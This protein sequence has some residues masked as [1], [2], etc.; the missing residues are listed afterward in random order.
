MSYG[1]ALEQVLSVDRQ[2]IFICSFNGFW[3]QAYLPPA[4]KAT[5]QANPGIAKRVNRGVLSDGVGLL[6]RCTIRPKEERH[7]DLRAPPS[8]SE[9]AESALCC[10]ANQ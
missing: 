7:V 3:K 8:P 9:T 1:A 5:R 10:R 4:R 6:R 2:I